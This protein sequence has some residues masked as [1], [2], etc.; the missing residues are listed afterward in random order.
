MR[1]ED[2]AGAQPL[3]RSARSG[4]KPHTGDAFR[5]ASQS[6]DAEAPARPAAA[7]P[8]AGISALL[9][10]QIDADP[11]KET[12]KR[13]I[14]RG[15]GLLD[16]LERL[17]AALLVGA[18]Q[19]ADWDALAVEYRRPRDADLP[20]DVAAL[21]DEVDVRVAVELAKRGR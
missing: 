15:I 10:L 2:R 3:A 13:A 1:V 6:G 17:K 12:R 9:Q 5:I 19:A 8:S 4:Q 11:Q 14:R 20:P 7:L 21:L 16:G 18:D